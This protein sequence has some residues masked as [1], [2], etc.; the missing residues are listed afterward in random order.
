MKDMSRRERLL[1]HVAKELSDLLEH[2]KDKQLH[3][4]IDDSADYLIELLTR[5]VIELSIEEEK[6]H[7]A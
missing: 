1:K 3:E 5:M 2:R 6:E 7:A 4:Y